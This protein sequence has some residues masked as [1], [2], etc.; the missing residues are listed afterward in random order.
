MYALIQDNN[1]V[2]VAAEQFPVHPSMTWVECPDDCT[3]QWQYED[4]QCVEPVPVE[5]S[6]EDVEREALDLA[7]R[8]KLREIA[9]A[10]LKV[11][12]TVDDKGALVKK[13]Q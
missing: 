5:V 4:G 3:T 7:I 2:Q 1:I 12:G 8:D 11:D 9:M 13:E 10:E 6:K